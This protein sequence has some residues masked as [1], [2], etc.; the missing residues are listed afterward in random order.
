MVAFSLVYSC[1][2]VVLY[3]H[4]LIYVINLFSFYTGILF[5]YCIGVT[6]VLILYFFG[7]F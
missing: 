7:F 4:K 6:F 5:L 2:S 3:L 1:F